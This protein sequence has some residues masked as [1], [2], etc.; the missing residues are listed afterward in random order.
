MMIMPLSIWDTLAAFMNTTVNAKMP[1]FTN[2]AIILAATLCAFTVL[3][4]AYDYIQGNTQTSYWSV[5]RP[6]VIL[7][8]VCQFNTIILRPFTGIVN[9]FTREVAAQAGNVDMEYWKNMQKNNLDI[10]ASKKRGINN[11]YDKEL[12]EIGEDKSVVGKFFYKIKLW[13]KKVLMHTLNCSTMTIGAIIGGLL[14]LIAKILLFVQ[15]MLSALYLTILSIIG[16]FIFALAILPGFEGGIKSWIS[17]Y[18]Q[19]A[20]WIPVGYVI[21]ALNLAL[22]T[23]FSKSAVAAG[24]TMADEWLM[25]ANEIV[26]IVSI[27]SVPKICQWFIESTGANDAHSALSQPTRTAARKLLKF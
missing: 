3:K 22:G 7:I 27:A 24:A 20:L 25:I 23:S 8:L 4:L 18:I 12:R 26:T 15:Q 14:M 19:I 6:L 1:S 13:L 5:L 10:V 21:M 11:E 9:V 2:L 17:R 16:P